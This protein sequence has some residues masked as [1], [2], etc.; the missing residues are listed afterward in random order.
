MSQGKRIQEPYLLVSAGDMSG[1]ITSASFNVKNLNDIALQFI[2]TGSP[3]GTFYV[4]A[5]VNGTT[6]G[7]ITTEPATISASGAAGNHEI[8]L[9]GY[10][11]PF[12]R[13]FYDFSSG[14]GSLNVYLSAK[15]N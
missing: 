2:F 7:S 13:V 9:E 4:Q 15:G 1:D 12:I 8:D 6:W 3:T 11:F 5:S 14:T 10:S